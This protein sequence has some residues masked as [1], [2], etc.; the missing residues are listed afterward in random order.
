MQA[1]D[2]FLT[3]LMQGPKQFLIPI[4]QRTYSWTQF[5]C[6][7]LLRDIGR[8]G[9]H[10]Y[11]QSHFVGSIGFKGTEVLKFGKSGRRKHWLIA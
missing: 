1:R 5:N 10:N 4:F 3:Q 11:V 9:E 6:D 2:V 8:A 7:Q